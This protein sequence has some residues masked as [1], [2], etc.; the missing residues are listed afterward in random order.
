MRTV[1]DFRSL[2]RAR[3]IRNRHP[4]PQYYAL[5]LPRT[6]GVFHHD[7]LGRINVLDDHDSRIRAQM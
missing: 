7:A 2:R 4:R 6:V 3:A 1:M 5:E